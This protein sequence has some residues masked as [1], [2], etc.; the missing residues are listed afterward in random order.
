VYYA[1]AGLGN[2]I[3]C[4]CCDKILGEL[5]PDGNFY[6]RT[7]GGK[8]RRRETLYGPMGVTVWCERGTDTTV[9]LRTVTAL[10]TEYAPALA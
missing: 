2:Q 8:A 4:R 6:Q 10:T 3:R 5:T 9:E 1:S 7:A